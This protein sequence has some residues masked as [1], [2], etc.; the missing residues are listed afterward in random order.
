MED[1]PVSQFLEPI[2]KSGISRFG[3]TKSSEL[4]APIFGSEAAAVIPSAMHFRRRICFVSAHNILVSICG[5]ELVLF[6]ADWKKGRH[7]RWLS[8]AGFFFRPA[9]QQCQ[10]GPRQNRFFKEMIP[11]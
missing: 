1:D 7:R 11:V 9:R 2:K 5:I 8:G 4:R 6:P 10:T 3:A